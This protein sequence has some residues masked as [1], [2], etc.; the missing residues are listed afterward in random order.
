MTDYDLD[1]NSNLFYARYNTDRKNICIFI[2]FEG[3]LPTKKKEAFKV[4]L[5]GI[6]RPPTPAFIYHEYDYSGHSPGAHV[7]ELEF[8]ADDVAHWEECWRDKVT[9]S[10]SAVEAVGA[11]YLWINDELGGPI[12]PG[13]PGFD[14]NS[15]E[16]AIWSSEMDRGW[17][18]DQP[19]QEC[20]DDWSQIGLRDDN[21]EGDTK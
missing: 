17:I 12:P 6:W 16:F 2:S 8:V 21:Y 10:I 14:A 9:A 3:L 18:A 19:T 20:S 1:G 5:N 7:L 4:R 11:R 15:S 13:L